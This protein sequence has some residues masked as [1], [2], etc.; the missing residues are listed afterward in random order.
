MK[1]ALKDYAIRI[2]IALASFLVM[3]VAM[4]LAFPFILLYAFERGMVDRKFIWE[5]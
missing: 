1:A 5:Y 3:L 4:P 2:S